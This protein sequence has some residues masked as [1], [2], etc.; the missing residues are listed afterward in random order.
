MKFEQVI[1]SHVQQVDV[2]AQYSRSKKPLFAKLHDLN[3]FSGK[4]D[5][6]VQL[7]TENIIEK[8]M[9]AAGS[10]KSAEKRFIS[11]MWC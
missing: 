7:V 2:V 9:L 10:A 11:L 4:V 8:Q 1:M 3:N 5:E 6:K